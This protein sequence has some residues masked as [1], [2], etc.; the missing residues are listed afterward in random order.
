MT[1]LEEIKQGANVFVREKYSNVLDRNVAFS[2]FLHGAEYG[3]KTMIDRICEWLDNRLSG[4]TITN[5]NFGDEYKV[6]DLI[7]DLRK[8][9]K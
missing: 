6:E 3:D 1:R 4:Y 5:F 8:K 7:N 2:A 9:I